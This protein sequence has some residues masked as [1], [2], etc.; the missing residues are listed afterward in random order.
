MVHGTWALGIT[1]IADSV[2]KRQTPGVKSGSCVDFPGEGL[3]NLPPLPIPSVPA[4]TFGLGLPPIQLERQE[5]PWKPRSY[6]GKVVLR[7][8]SLEQGSLGLNPNSAEH[9]CG[10]NTVARCVPLL[11]THGFSVHG[12][13]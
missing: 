1:D 5:S 2:A 12:I 3:A 8:Q 4:W 11:A 13:S 10:H 7:T 9:L 6:S